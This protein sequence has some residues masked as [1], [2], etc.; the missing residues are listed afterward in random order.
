[1]GPAGQPS[2]GCNAPET[3]EN[4]N[5]SHPSTFPLPQNF[6]GILWVIVKGFQLEGPGC[7]HP[8]MEAVSDV[9]ADGT[10][11]RQTVAMSEPLGWVQVG[12]QK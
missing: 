1:M 7:Q 3:S 10:F 6:Q 4:A 2:V 5:P 12:V 8:E 11:S 9:I